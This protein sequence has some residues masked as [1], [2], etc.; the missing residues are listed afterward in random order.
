MT[1]K[2]LTVEGRRLEISH[3]DKVLFPGAGITKADLV[4]YYV[5]IAEVMLP[6]VRGRPIS[7]ERY[8]DGVTGGHFFQK[9]APDYF[10]DWVPRVSVRVKEEGTEQPQVMCDDAATLAYIAEQACITPHTWLS[11]APRLDHPDKLVFDL[12]PPGD[13]FDIVR[14]AARAVRAVLRD[15]GLNAL[16]MTTGSRGLHVVVP[17][18]GE[19][20]FDAAR[21]FAR[22][23]SEETARRA[24]GRFTTETRKEDRRGRLFLDYLRNAYAQTSVPPYAVRARRGAPVAAPL[25][26]YEL[27]DRALNSRTYNVGNIFRRLGHKAEPWADFGGRAQSLARAR[28]RLDE[29]LSAEKY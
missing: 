26:W 18:D 7:M 4:G 10:P 21:E 29:L 19:A 13:D 27:D 22:R 28:R 9:E 6:H 2:T 8:P 1:T 3:A 16:L 17:L 11:R 25:D 24:P 15:A 23:L 14:E 12:D 20:N 5:R